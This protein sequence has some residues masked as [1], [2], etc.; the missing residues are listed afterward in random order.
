MS[1]EKLTTVFKG[2]IWNW[3][4]ATPVRLASLIG[5]IILGPGV[6]VFSVERILLKSR[7]QFGIF[8]P[9]DEKFERK[10]LETSSCQMLKN[11][12]S[13]KVSAKKYSVITGGPGIG[14]SS[15]SKHTA[16]LLG[17]KGIV[18]VRVPMSG[19]PNE[20]EDSLAERLHLYHLV[21]D[22]VYP[23][24]AALLLDFPKYDGDKKSSYLSI[25]IKKLCVLSTQYKRWH[26]GKSIVV[27]ID[28]VDNFMKDEKGMKYLEI[29]QDTAK[30]MA[31]SDVVLCLIY[32]GSCVINFVFIFYHL[33]MTRKSSSCLS[34]AKEKHL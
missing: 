27:V 13:P 30:E 4:T 1:P 2:T 3:V 18:Y 21:N 25:I 9:E 29:L 8:V 32:I 19:D 5:T 6:C 31:V 23:F 12:I 33:R 14:I 7:I 17:H 20:F 10:F 28:Q 24:T 11:V 22:K 16:D 15:A 34:Q 26:G